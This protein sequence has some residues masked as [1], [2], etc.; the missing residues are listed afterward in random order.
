MISNGPVTSYRYALYH[1]FETGIAYDTLKM[2]RM[3]SPSHQLRLI[4]GLVLLKLE[5]PAATATNVHCT[6]VTQCKAQ[7]KHPN[8][9]CDDK[10]A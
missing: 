3:H 4:W 6:V 2:R 7:Q 10:R 5:I 1:K 9:P 8:F